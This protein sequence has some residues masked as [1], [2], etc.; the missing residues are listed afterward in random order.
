MDVLRLITS[1]RAKSNDAGLKSPTIS[2]PYSSHL[3]VGSAQESLGSG[4]AVAKQPKDGS[5]ADSTSVQPRRLPN[6]E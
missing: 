5:I 2:S 6:S 1:L 3:S 4:L